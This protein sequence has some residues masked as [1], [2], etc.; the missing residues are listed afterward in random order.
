M[1][2]AAT[3]SRPYAAAAFAL[4]RESSLVAEW[5]AFLD[6]L[7]ALVETPQMRALLSM[8]G[9][10]PAAAASVCA[11]AL[12]AG[13]AKAGGGGGGGG[14]SGDYPGDLWRSFLRALAAARRLAA[15]PAVARR[16]AALRREAEGIEKIRIETARELSSTALD[17]LLE[18][19]RQKTGKTIEAEIVV[20]PELLGGARV[21]V[22]GDVIDASARGRLLRLAR[23]LA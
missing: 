17:S 20:A 10:S 7:A 15:A 23:A 8:P 6:D 4:A 11:D 3:A 12:V 2:D 19:L 9:V 14:D 16:F 13:R 1:T 22:G 18:Q 21:Q 5:G